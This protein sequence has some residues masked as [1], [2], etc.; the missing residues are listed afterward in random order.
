MPR[1]TVWALRS[2]LVYLLIGFTAGAILLAHKGMAWTPWAW[3]WLPVHIVALLVGW[4]TQ[5]A[6][7]VAFW[8]LP[9]FGTRRGNVPLAWAA[10]GLLNAGLALAVLTTLLG[11]GRSVWAVAQALQALGVLAFAVHAWP[12]IKPALT[13]AERSR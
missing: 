8:I 13:A 6:I 5:L 10:W 12:R 11:W 1:L 2:A 3:Q 9:R 4:M 7:G